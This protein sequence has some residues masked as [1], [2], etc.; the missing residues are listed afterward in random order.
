M[1]D[2]IEALK[3]KKTYIIV[4]AVIVLGVLQGLGIFTAPEAIWPILVAIGGG[5]MAA[6]VNRIAEAFKK[7]NG[8]G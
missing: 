4:I 6:K 5:T 7:E 8:D 1:N 2:I 3:G